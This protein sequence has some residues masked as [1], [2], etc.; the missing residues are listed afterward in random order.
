M[1][2]YYILHTI[3]Q[4]HIYFVPKKYQVHWYDYIL[5]NKKYHKNSGTIHSISSSNTTY[6]IGMTIYYIPKCYY[7]T[8]LDYILYTIYQFHIY[9]VPK[10]Y[11]VHWYDYILY[12]KKYHKNSGTIHSISSSNTTYFIGMTI[13]YIPKCY[14]YTILV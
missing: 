4:F 14:Y 7:Y 12:N 5:Y 1:T 9:F 8:I 11:Q 3:Y 10:K 13:Y 6:F 2:I